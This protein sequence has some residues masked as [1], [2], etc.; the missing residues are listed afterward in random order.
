M[1]QKGIARFATR[2]N[3]SYR[4]IA[5]QLQRW[6]DH[7]LHSL[8]TTREA[9]N[10]ASPEPVDACQQSAHQT[11]NHHLLLDN[12]TF[13]RH[14]YGAPSFN[15]PSQ[16]QFHAQSETSVASPVEYTQAILDGKCTGLLD[17]TYFPS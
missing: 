17:N 2:E 15:W 3:E 13:R 7:I 14:V 6:N 4:M 9:E 11:K 5:G 1:V 12:S 16:A 8:T 10:R